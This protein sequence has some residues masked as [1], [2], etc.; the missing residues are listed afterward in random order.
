MRPKLAS[1]SSLAWMPKATSWSISQLSLFL[2]CKISSPRDSQV[3]SLKIIH[4]IKSLSGLK[5]CNFSPSIWAKIQIVYQAF[6]WRETEPCV[7][8]LLSQ[9]LH[10]GN[11]LSLSHCSPWSSDGWLFLCWPSFSAQTSL[12]AVPVW[13]HFNSLQWLLLILLGLVV[14]IYK[15]CA[16]H[17]L[18]LYP[19]HTPL[20]GWSCT[21]R[22]SVIIHK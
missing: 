8:S 15:V 12:P 21:P 1:S 20:L 18:N 19:F 9:G 13:S 7:H 22:V 3:I 16:T 4:G 10:L 14:N 2:F 17:F 6:R 5:P 11:A